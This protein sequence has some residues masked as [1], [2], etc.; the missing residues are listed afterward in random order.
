MQDN[1]GEALA[2]YDTRQLEWCNQYIKRLREIELKKFD[3]ISAKVFEFMDVHTKLTPEQIARNE[4]QN[5]RGA[6]GDQTRMET[7]KNV[8][9]ENDIMF[10][11]W[12][13]VLSRN[14]Y[15]IDIKFG[16]HVA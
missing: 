13:N 5:K 4:Q 7:Y 9:A 8:S 15:G 6:K 1:M 10:G 14:Q 16:N 3:E 2:M 12:A 11:I